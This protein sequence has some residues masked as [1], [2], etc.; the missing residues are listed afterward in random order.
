MAIKAF[1]CLLVIFCMSGCIVVDNDYRLQRSISAALEIMNDTGQPLM[2]T[3]I[4]QSTDS[5]AVFA[6][7]LNTIERAQS[8]HEKI[9][10]DAYEAIVAGQF[11]LKG[12]CGDIKTWTVNGSEGTGAHL[13]SINAV[14]P[15]RK[16]RIV[17][18]KCR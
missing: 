8:R 15:K 6:I 3:S 7:R 2:L 16:V 14:E 5:Q 10:A 17:V 4:H 13:L 11:L 1:L 9:Q 12:G 18:H